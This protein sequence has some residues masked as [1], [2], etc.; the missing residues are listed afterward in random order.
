MTRDEKYWHNR[1]RNLWSKYGITLK[2]YD[3]MF[4]AQAGVCDICQ[5]S[6]LDNRPLCVDH[7]HKTGKVRGLLCAGCNANLAW[8]EKLYPHDN[9]LKMSLE[10]LD[11]Y[12]GY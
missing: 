6:Q 4:L 8:I 10:Y 11:K 12:K 9:R 7:N 1:E 5:Q 3:R 2:D